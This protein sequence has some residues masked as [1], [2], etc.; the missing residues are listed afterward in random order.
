MHFLVKYESEYTELS[1]IK[2]G[3]LLGSVLGPLLYLLYTANQP[4]SIET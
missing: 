2:A 3:V 4:P 1:S